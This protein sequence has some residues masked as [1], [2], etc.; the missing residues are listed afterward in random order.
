MGNI[1]GVVGLG[2]GAIAFEGIGEEG[3]VLGGGI[4]RPL[5]VPVGIADEPLPKRLLL[6]TI[7][8]FMLQLFVDD[9]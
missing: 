2:Q 4:E 9:G 1:G 7:S 5:V 8:F 3:V 6:G